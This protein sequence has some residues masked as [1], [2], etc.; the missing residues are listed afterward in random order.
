MFWI[1]LLPALLVFYIGRHVHEP[2]VFNINRLNKVPGK[3]LDIFAPGI[4]STTML[5]ALVAL[6]AQGGFYA[7]TTWLPLYL[8]STRGLSVFDTGKY[9]CVIISGS[10]AG[11]VTGAYLSDKLGRKSTL[12]LFAVCSFVIVC[13][14][15]AVPISNATML[16]LGFPLGFFPSG[17]FSP[18]GAFFTELFPTRIRGSAQGFSY[19]L[20]RGGGAAFPA[21]VGFLSVRAG[22]GFAIA[23]LAGFAYLLMVIG[24]LLLPETKGRELQV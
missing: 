21:L 1:G 7:V 18:I 6:G 16:V 2:D 4:V 15:M 10:F 8:A 12:V 11:Y 14:Y 17:S 5:A 3:L 20:G 9:L 13:F 22:L 19:N 23:F 24:V